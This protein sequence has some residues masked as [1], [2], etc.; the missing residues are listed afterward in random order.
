[1]HGT[2]RHVVVDASNHGDPEDPPWSPGQLAGP[3]SYGGGRVSVAVRA[4]GAEPGRCHLA[5]FSR[6]FSTSSFWCG[7]PAS[8]CS[9]WGHVMDVMDPVATWHVIVPSREQ[10]G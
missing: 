4:P 6:N 3:T 5:Q 1:M 10:I 9:Y 2:C 7:A 8:L